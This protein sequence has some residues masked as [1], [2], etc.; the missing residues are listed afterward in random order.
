MPSADSTERL[1]S[2]SGPTSRCSCQGCGL[3]VE[4]LLVA[5]ERGHPRG[6]DAGGRVGPRPVGLDARRA[7]PARSRSAPRRRTAA[8]WPGPARRRRRCRRPRAS[9]GPPRRRA[10]GRGTSRRRAGG[11]RAASS[12]RV[13]SSSL[14]A[15]AANRWWNRNQLRF[16][17]SGT[18]NRLVRSRSRSRV[19]E[20][21]TPATWSQSERREAVEDGDRRDEAPH[22]LGVPAEHLLGEVV[23]DEAVAAAERADELVG[24]VATRQR[25]RG[26]VETGG[27]ALRALH[28]GR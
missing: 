4:G 8:S 7:S 19:A 25:Q 3:V 21:V 6:R 2:G 16:S 1:P 17:S 20:P 26:Q 13:I 10:R 12:G 27:P 15:T 24:V 11:A 14:R 5:D 23:A 28:E 9:G 18:R 22:L